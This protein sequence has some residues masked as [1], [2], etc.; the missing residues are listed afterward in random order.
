MMRQ[1]CRL[2]DLLLKSK[3]S[4]TEEPD[5]IHVISSCTSVASRLLEDIRLPGHRA[6]VEQRE[7]H[8]IE[9]SERSE[10]LQPGRMLNHLQ[11]NRTIA[12]AL[13]HSAARDPRKSTIAV[14]LQTAAASSSSSQRRCFNT[15]GTTSAFLAAAERVRTTES[16]ICP[17]SC[18]PNLL[19]HIHGDSRR[20]MIMVLLMVWTI[21]RMRTR[22][23]KTCPRDVI[24]DCGPNGALD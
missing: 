21:P 9:K 15:S 17:V 1:S 18:L 2:L 7:I 19:P 24:G 14:R 20:H 12:A 8:Q 23:L 16:T 4:G 11:V 3:Q 5:L 22:P 6:A 13:P 10:I